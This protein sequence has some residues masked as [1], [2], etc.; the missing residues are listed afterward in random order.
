MRRSAPATEGVQLGLIITP[1]LDMAFQL[2]AFFI[3]TYHPSAL[4][5]HI[6]GDLTPPPANSGPVNPLAIPD[7]NP[8]VDPLGEVVVI[9]VAAVKRGQE[10]GDRHEGEPSRLSIQPP[11]QA[12]PTLIADASVSWDE[13][14]RKLDAA[15]RD[16]KK[17]E[18][19]LNIAADG[20]LRH[21]YVNDVFDACKR[22]GH[23]RISFVSPRKDR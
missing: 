18:A 12:T 16:L 14:L 22:A 21:R 8:G 3:M 9:S 20:N 2:L 6:A 15:L 13:A 23:Q 11:E 10:E 4:E 5:A 19:R 1:M 7:P 17:R